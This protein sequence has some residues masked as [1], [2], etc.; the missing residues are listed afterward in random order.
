MS[1]KQKKAEEKRVH[2][3]RKVSVAEAIL[4]FGKKAFTVDQLITKV[5]KVYT[6]HGGKANPK[7]SRFCVSYSLPVLVGLEV[8]KVEGKKY[9]FTR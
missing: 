7:E 8:V 5:D 2:Y 9:T 6:S 1:K 4:S 3:S